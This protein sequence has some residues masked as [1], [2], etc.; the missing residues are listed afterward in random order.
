MKTSSRTPGAAWRRFEAGWLGPVDA[1]IYGLLR[2]AFSVVV[3]LNLADLWP[4]REAFFSGEGMVDRE[5]MR[6]AHGVGW[7]VSLFH[8][9]DSPA[10]VTGAFAVAAAAAVCLGIGIWPRVMIILVFAWQLSYTQR[11]FPVIHGWDILLRIQAFILMISPLGPSLRSILGRA[12]GGGGAVRRSAVWA[13]RHGLVLMQ[14]QLAVVYWQ[15]IWLKL[16]DVSWRNGE[17]ISYFM[18]S[19]YSRFPSAAWAHWETA[20][21]LLTYATLVVEISVPLLLWQRRTRWLGFVAGFGLHLGILAVSTIWLF[22]LAILVPYLAFLEGDDLDRLGAGRRRLGR[23]RI[24]P[25]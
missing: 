8:L 22:S 13:P 14:V 16:A 7:R 24:E 1:R 4:H 21:A 19:L 6:T 12:A 3:L 25:V 11:A 9:A 15:T 18:M 10:V 5:T 2:V 20:S 23:P 17:F